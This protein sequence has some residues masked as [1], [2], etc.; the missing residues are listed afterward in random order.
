MI[1]EEIV[2]IP[3]VLEDG[4]IQ[5]QEIIYFVK[6]GKRISSTNHRKVI[7]PGDDVSAET[8]NVKLIADA[9]HTQDCIDAYEAKQAALEAELNPVEIE[10]E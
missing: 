2:E 5:I 10:K 8:G 3:T 4:Q 7:A 1:T 9:V 6:D